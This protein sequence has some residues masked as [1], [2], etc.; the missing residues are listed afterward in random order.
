MAF[1]VNTNRP[2]NI[3]DV[4]RPATTQTADTQKLQERFLSSSK[5]F[6]DSNS[7]VMR[8]A[9]LIVVLVMFLILLRAG[10]MALG[11]LMSPAK[12]PRLID[13]MMDGKH[14]SVVHMDPKLKSSKPILR[15]VNQRDGIEFTWSVWI[16]IEDLEYKR[17][18]IKHI[19]HKGNDNIDSSGLNTPNNS[20]GLYLAADTN[21]LLVL[22]NTFNKIQE[23]II[24][25]DIPLNKWI[26]VIIRC[27]GRNLD[28]YINGTIVKRHVL[29]GVPKQN[30][31]DVYMSMNGGFSGFTSNLW[32]YDYGLGLR[33][34]TKIANNGP[35]LTMKD[36]KMT[37]PRHKYLSERWYLD[38]LTN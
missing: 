21:E 16:F 26:N 20:P 29:S 17:G 10:T 36:S 38:Q 35:S 15:S 24:V 18:T 22:M 5:L 19:F 33:E 9:F 1:N 3:F 28:V 34:I 37:D 12:N 7:V 32:Y 30:Y 6:L 23:T 11:Y 13:G 8:F 14:M 27:K 2:S 25:E 31:G 4:F